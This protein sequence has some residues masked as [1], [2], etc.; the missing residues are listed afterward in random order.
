M[1]YFIGKTSPS[2]GMILK[3]F[4][5]FKFEPCLHA[6]MEDVRIRIV[7]KK[8]LI[9]ISFIIGMWM[10]MDLGKLTHYELEYLENVYLCQHLH[11][12][13]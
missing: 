10:N 8:M 2:I 4:N 3:I 1:G 6:Q 11:Y 13:L 5:D 12:C 9:F 7:I